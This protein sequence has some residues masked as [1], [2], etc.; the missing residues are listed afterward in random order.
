MFL[1]LPEQENLSQ[2]D[3]FEVKSKIILFYCF[4]YVGVFPAWVSLYRCPFCPRRQ[5]KKVVKC[6]IPGPGV[7]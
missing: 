6:W 7:I 3:V 4:M 2:N 5:Q 1:T